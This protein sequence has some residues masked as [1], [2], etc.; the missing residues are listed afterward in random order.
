V[1]V[2]DTLRVRLREALEASPLNLKAVADR[3]GYTAGYIRAIAGRST[4]DQ[5]NPTV[6]AVWAIAGALDVDPLWLLGK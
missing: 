4:R 2:H 5:R 3:S 1:N 6:G